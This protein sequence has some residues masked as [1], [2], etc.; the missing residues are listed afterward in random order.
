MK[1]GHSPPVEIEVQSTEVS[2]LE[3]GIVMK[4]GATHRLWRLKAEHRGSNFLDWDC[5][6][7]GAT[8]RLW[9]LKMQS[10]SEYLDWIVI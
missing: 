6:K 4:E 10:T 9:R 2:K 1:R 3:L 8:H 5:D 7:E